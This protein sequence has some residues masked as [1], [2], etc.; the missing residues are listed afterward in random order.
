MTNVVKMVGK[1]VENIKEFKADIIVRTKLGHL[2]KQIFTEV[3]EVY[4]FML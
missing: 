3:G 2:V 1:R 4:G